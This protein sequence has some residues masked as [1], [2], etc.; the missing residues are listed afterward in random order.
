MLLLAFFNNVNFKFSNQICVF[1]G[2]LY[3]VDVTTGPESKS[4]TP[5]RVFFK[6]IGKNGA[7]GEVE[8]GKDF[9]KGRYVQ[10]KVNKLMGRFDI[11]SLQYLK[12]T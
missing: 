2:V 9:S 4:G 12:L 3:F 7:H 11:D 6:L 5:S 8:L 10:C 1:L